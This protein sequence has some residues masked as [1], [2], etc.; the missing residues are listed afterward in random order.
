MSIGHIVAFS[1][2]TLDGPQWAVFLMMVDSL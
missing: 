1:R 2:Q